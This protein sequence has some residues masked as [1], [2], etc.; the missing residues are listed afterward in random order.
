MVSTPSTYEAATER[1]CK[2]RALWGRT[3]SGPLSSPCGEELNISIS[4]NCSGGNTEGTPKRNNYTRRNS[5]AN[6]H[7]QTLYTVIVHSKTRSQFLRYETA[8]AE[9]FGC[10]HRILLH[11][12]QKKYAIL[13]RRLPTKI[14]WPKTRDKTRVVKQ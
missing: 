9:D 12:A 7:D 5:T 6:S 2:I 1:R 11:C 10:Q 8:E 13:K 4:N 14:Y 3:M